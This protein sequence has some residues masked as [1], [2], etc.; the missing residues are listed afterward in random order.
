M[1]Q[2]QS[3][4]FLASQLALSPS[5]AFLFFKAQCIPKVLNASLPCVFLIK[6]R[7][8]LFFFVFFRVPFVG[9][10]LAVPLVF[11]PRS[12]CVCVTTRRLSSRLAALE[13]KRQNLTDY[14]RFY[15]LSQN[16]I[17]AN[18]C[19]TPPPV[20]DMYRI[21]SDYSIDYYYCQ[22]SIIGSRHFSATVGVLTG[23]AF[24]SFFSKEKKK[25]KS[26]S[27]A[28]FPSHRNRVQ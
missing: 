12:L 26:T 5:C 10:K 21:G 18:S 2:V 6:S 8:F 28:R 4:T 13:K 24:Y 22:I 27:P 3:P 16:A 19:C 17:M 11:P 14:Y 1:Q 20:R 7:S 9:A 15:C 23:P 25:K